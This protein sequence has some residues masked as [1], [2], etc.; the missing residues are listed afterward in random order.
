ML[1]HLRKRQNIVGIFYGHL[2]VFVSPSHCSIDIAWREGF[3]AKMLPGIS[4]EDCLLTDLD[5]DPVI[6]GCLMYEATDLLVRNKSLVPSSHSIVFHIQTS[7]CLYRHGGFDDKVS[8]R[9]QD[10]CD[11]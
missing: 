7:F 3:T 4:A 8:T 10:T 11:L 9:S 2:G 6:L 1:V 5:I